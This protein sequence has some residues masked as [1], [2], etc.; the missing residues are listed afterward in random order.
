MIVLRCTRKLL[1]R[2]GRPVE[3]PDPSTSVLGDWYA[4]PFQIGPKRLILLMSGASRLP[5]VMHARDVANLGRNFPDALGAVLSAIG[6]PAATV[7]AEVERS[8]QFVYSTTDSRSVLGSLNDFAFMAQHRARN[9]AEIDVVEMAVALSGT[10]IIAMKFG[11]P[12][13]VTL[14]L[15]AAQGLRVLSNMHFDP[16]PGGQ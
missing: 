11:F 7:D 12:R 4:K 6:A 15:L 14:K 10:P 2:V 16:T 1:D 8:R 5:V 13:D 9:V 3:S